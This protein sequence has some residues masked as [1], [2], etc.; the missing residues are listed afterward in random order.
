MLFK[1]HHLKGIKS[2]D[3]TLAFR[4]WKTERVKEGSLI[5]SPIGQILIEEIS[6]IQ[7]EDVNYEEAILAGYQNREEL[8]QLLEKRKEG[9]I[10]RIKLKYDS[11]D[12]RIALREKDEISDKELKQVLLKLD[13]LDRYSKQ[14]KWTKEVMIAIKDNPR[15]RAKDL[16]EMLDK[17][18]DWLKPNIRKLKNLGLTISHGVGYSLSPRGKIVLDKLIEGKR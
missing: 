15:L 7:L 6:D 17:E 4:K 8:I 18:K 11:P 14:G 1:I 9:N 3:I 16:A 2:G 12:P 13:R 5:K 10:Y